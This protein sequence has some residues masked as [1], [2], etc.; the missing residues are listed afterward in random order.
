MSLRELILNKISEYQP[1]NGLDYI[2]RFFL[3]LISVKHEKVTGHV[4][5]VALLAE[6]IAR[7]VKTDS[8]AAF[9]AG[10]MHDVGKLVLPYP[11]FEGYDI[12]D[13]EYEEI[14]K[15]AI[16]GSEVLKDDYIFTSL[17]VGLHHAMYDKGYGL[18][19]KDFPENYSPA[20]IK[21][22]LEISTIVSISD[23]IEAF[24]HRGGKMK[25]DSGVVENDLKSM[26]Y[27]KYL[28]DIRLVDI[29][30]EEYSKIEY[31]NEEII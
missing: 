22:V 3:S 6:A 20:L 7:R 8:K 9:F 5:R 29:A 10:L 16:L 4:E 15:H 19:M 27:A 24:T 18:T 23:F 14:K 12:N 26:L 17:C 1:K 30:L 13:E 25:S 11:L 2:A 28:N 31:W 21:M